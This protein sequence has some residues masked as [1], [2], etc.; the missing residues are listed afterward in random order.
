MSPLTD[1]GARVMQDNALDLALPMDLDFRPTVLLVAE[2][3]VETVLVEVP[4]PNGPWGARGLGELPFLPAAPAVGG[5][6]HNATGV[7]VAEF[8]F[9][10]ERVLRALGKF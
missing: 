4:D 7:W 2:G 3:K 6:I 10:P 9:T 5:A 1:L 8:P